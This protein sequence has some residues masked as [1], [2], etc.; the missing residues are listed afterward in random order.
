MATYKTLNIREVL[1]GAGVGVPF[2]F[3]GALLLAGVEALSVRGSDNLFL[4][5]VAG[6]ILMTHSLI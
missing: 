4:P 3:F 5:I 1:V 6:A 2:A